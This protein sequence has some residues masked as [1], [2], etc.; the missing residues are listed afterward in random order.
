[1][2]CP[3]SIAAAFCIFMPHV[4]A[5]EPSTLADKGKMLAVDS[6]SRCHV[7]DP[8]KPFSG[9]SSTPSF[10]LMV[11]NL[12]DWE[13]RFQSFQNRLPH[14]SIVRFEDDKPDPTVEDLRPPVLLKYEDIDALVA[15]AR[16]LIK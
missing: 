7:V 9:I 14:P 15:Y 13:E 6:C 8:S 2:K 16:S 5:Q 10:S 4:A 11:N 3:L 12:E 1:M